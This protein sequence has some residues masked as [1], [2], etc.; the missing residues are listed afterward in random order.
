MP[1]PALARGR[2]SPLWRAYMPAGMQSRARLMWRR[3]WRMP[4]MWLRLRVYDDPR[5]ER[6][7]A[8]GRS[9]ARSWERRR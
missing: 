3:D 2:P 5:I 9:L 6:R 1:R 7:V 8:M 4:V